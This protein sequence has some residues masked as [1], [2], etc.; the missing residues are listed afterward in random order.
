[1]GNEAQVGSKVGLEQLVES[2]TTPITIYFKPKMKFTKA[3][4]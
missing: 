3:L 1:M 2:T 4:R